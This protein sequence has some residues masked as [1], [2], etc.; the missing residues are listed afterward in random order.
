MIDANAKEIEHKIREAKSHARRHEWREAAERYQEALKLAPFEA[1]LWLMTGICLRESGRL[2]DAIQYL[3][4][5]NMLDDSNLHVDIELGNTLHVVGRFEE[6]AEI[7]SKARELHHRQLRDLWTTRHCP[8]LDLS[9]FTGKQTDG[10][11]GL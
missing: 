7:F 2:P 3:E 9:F 5:A 4:K 11:S 8:T 6:A 1:E 10:H